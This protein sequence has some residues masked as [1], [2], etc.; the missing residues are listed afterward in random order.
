MVLS[1]TTSRQGWLNARLQRTLRTKVCQTGAQSLDRGTGES[2]TMTH[3]TSSEGTTVRCSTLWL[4]GGLLAVALVGVLGWCHT[5]GRPVLTTVAVGRLPCRVVVDEQSRRAFVGQ[6]DQ[7][8]FRRQLECPLVRWWSHHAHRSQRVVGATAAMAGGAPS[9]GAVA[10]PAGATD[11]RQ[12]H[13][14]RRVTSV[15][16]RLRSFDP[17][18]GYVLR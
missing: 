18:P 6:P 12:R 9:R 3:E 4:G 2:T 10:A 15:M 14:P 11:A 13:R 5:S 7:P 17:P 16:G 1:H 8:C